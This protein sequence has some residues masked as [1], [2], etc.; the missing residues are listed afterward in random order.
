MASILAPLATFLVG[1]ECSTNLL[2]FLFHF[3]FLG[4]DQNAFLLCFKLAISK[5][6]GL[7]MVA[8]LN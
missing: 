5:G 3:S 7:G 4:N 2:F 1:E 8:G 6:L